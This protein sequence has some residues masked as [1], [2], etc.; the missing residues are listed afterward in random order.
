MKS[1]KHAVTK[2]TLQE[3]FLIGYDIENH[4]DIISSSEFQE[5]F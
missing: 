2:D 1:P 4:K 5:M 3:L